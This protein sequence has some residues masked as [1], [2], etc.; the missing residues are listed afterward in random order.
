ME[1][2]IIDVTYE[3][4]ISSI[5]IGGKP[6]NKKE[7]N[8]KL[9]IDAAKKG[10]GTHHVEIDEAHVKYKSFIRKTLLTL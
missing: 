2:L 7:L 9:A 8:R 4:S 3:I 10:E 5:I 6:L 1:N